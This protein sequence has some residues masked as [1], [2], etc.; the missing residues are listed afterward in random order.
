MSVWDWRGEFIG[1]V[2]PI[3]FEAIT[4]CID[5][6]RRAITCPRLGLL[7]FVALAWRFVGVRYM[8][9]GRE[10]PGDVGAL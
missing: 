10:I 4:C 7:R 3:K 1:L 8:K 2:E 6:D 5:L 9:N